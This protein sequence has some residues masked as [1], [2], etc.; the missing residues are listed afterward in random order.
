LN[1]TNE[2]DLSRKVFNRKMK[3]F[4]SIADIRI[5]TPSLWMAE[6]ARRSALLKDFPVQIIPNGLDTSVFKPVDK[7]IAR[8]EYGLKNDKKYILFGSIDPSGNRLKGFEELRK[9]IGYIDNTETELIVFGTKKRDPYPGLNKKIHYPGWI[10]NEEDLAT[11][12]SAADVMVVPSL[13]EAFGQTASEAMA[14]GTPVVAFDGTG[15]ADIVEHQKTGYLA[16]PFEP[17]SLAEGITWV[18][19]DKERLKGLSINARD[20]AVEEFDI[21]GVTDRY[22]SLY[23]KILS[24]QA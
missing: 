16:K 21:K 15:V 5:V 14:C 13:Q 1:S 12:Y 8:K 22:V 23:N 3:T 4:K 18:L 7:L 10:V 6:N 20:R 19:E 24:S 2:N 11:L 9:A 17:E